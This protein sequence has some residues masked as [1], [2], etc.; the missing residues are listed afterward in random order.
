MS[1]GLGSF[2]MK[3][4]H[5]STPRTPQPA[6]PGAVLATTEPSSSGIR[7]RGRPPG[8]KNK[9]PRNT[10]GTPQSSNIA[11]RSRMDTTPARPSG[12]RNTVASA[13]GIAVVVPSPSPSIADNKPRGRGRPR[14]SPKSSQQSSPIHRVYNCQWKGCPAELHNL[15]TLKRHAIKH[16]D[17]F[18][19]P[20]PCLWKGCGKASRD[21]EEDE[22][23]QP[24]EYATKDIW[25]RHIDRRHLADYA[26]KLGDGP[27]LRSD[28]EISDYVS[29]SAKRGGAPIISKGRGR[30]DSLPLTSG[31]KPAKLYHQA[32]GITT[33]LGKAQ[34]FLEASEARRRSLGP[35]MDRTGVTFVTK[36]KN[37]LL[38]DSVTPLKKVQHRDANDDV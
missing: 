19:G 20:F 37:A 27:S 2:S 30:P 28:S 8:A 21:D 18:S 32:H 25:A 38:D 10:S 33:E 22:G 17:K 1:S 14:K 11:P 3:P 13:D 6:S 26:W 16:G 24:L 12:L 36:R 31:G 23:T 9:H 35:G 5:E 29:D 7:R 34:A 4:T 15:E